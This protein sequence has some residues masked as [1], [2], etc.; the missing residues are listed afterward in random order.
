MGDIVSSE[1]TLQRLPSHNPTLPHTHT[2]EHIFYK[3][4]NLSNMDESGS[5]W[6]LGKVSIFV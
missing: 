1:G 2:W 4:I 6:I 3:N 5:A